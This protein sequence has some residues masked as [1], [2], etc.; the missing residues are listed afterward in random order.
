MRRLPAILSTRPINGIFPRSMDDYLS[1]MLKDF[2]PLF[3][4]DSNT[5]SFPV[6]ILEDDKRYVIKADIP[7]AKKEDIAVTLEDNA[8]TIQL[9]RARTEEKKEGTYLRRERSTAYTARTFSLPF[10][11][12]E[13]EIKAKYNEGTL[14]ISIPKSVEKQAR[15]ITIE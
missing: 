3:D 15:G 1:S 2:S 14:E 9:K 10:A 13:A 12:S 11:S 8:L 5:T 4:D 7:G 6:D